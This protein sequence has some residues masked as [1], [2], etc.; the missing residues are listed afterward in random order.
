MQ[1][2]A[3]LREGRASTHP[4]CFRNAGGA[5]RCRFSTADRCSGCSGAC[6]GS[7]FSQA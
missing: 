6:E 7:V 1:K 3:R 5:L 4:Q 2:H